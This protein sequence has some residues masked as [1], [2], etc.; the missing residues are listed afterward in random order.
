MDVGLPPAL[1]GHTHAL[2]ADPLRAWG[3]PVVVQWVRTLASVCDDAGSIPGLA[4]WVKDLVVL[5][6]VA[7]VAEVAPVLSGYACAVGWQLQL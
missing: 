7:Q 2:H 5:Q 6:A 1:T 4:Q 3:V